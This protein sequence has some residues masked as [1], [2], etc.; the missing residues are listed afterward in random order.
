MCHKIAEE[1]WSMFKMVQRGKKKKLFFSWV[2]FPALA[3]RQSLDTTQ[4]KRQREKQE[5]IGRLTYSGAAAEESSR[6]IS[7]QEFSSCMSVASTFT[8]LLSLPATSFLTLSITLVSTFLHIFSHHNRTG[9]VSVWELLP[10][11]YGDNRHQVC[12]TML[13]HPGNQ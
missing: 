3:N 8:M 2:N 9:F 1:K 13:K 6:D 12:I 5:W 11:F 7:E 10:H 4:Q